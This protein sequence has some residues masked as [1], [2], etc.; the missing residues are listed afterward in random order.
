[1]AITSYCILPHY[2]VG[3]AFAAMDSE[4]GLISH[5]PI[6]E[7]AQWIN[8][9]EFECPEDKWFG[10]NGSLIVRFPKSRE[11]DWRVKMATEI[12]SAGTTDPVVMYKNAQNAAHLIG[13]DLNEFLKELRKLSQDPNESLS[14]LC[15]KWLSKSRNH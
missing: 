13:M 9:K 11:N 8:C 2:T 3:V 10:I 14:T 7:S 6:P 15:D 4:L 5:S 1:M 12:V